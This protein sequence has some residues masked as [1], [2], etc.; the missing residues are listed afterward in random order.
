MRMEAADA[1]ALRSTVL[2]VLLC[3][4]VFCCFIAWRVVNVANLWIT[5]VWTQGYFLK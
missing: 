4:C 3:L 5:G 1:I 2:V